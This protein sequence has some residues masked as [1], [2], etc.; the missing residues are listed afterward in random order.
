MKTVLCILT[1]M[2]CTLFVSASDDF[3]QIIE[4]V[5]IAEGKGDIHYCIK[6]AD[7][8]YNSNPTKAFSK[9]ELFILAAGA[10]GYCLLKDTIHAERLGRYP[11][12]A[13][14]Q[15]YESNLESRF[16]ILPDIEKK[17][18]IKQFS[19]ALHRI[20]NILIYIEPQK[21]VRLFEYHHKLIAENKQ[22]FAFNTNEED[23]IDY[24]I[25]GM[26][27]KNWVHAHHQVNSIFETYYPVIQKYINSNNV[28]VVGIKLILPFLETYLPYVLDCSSSNNKYTQYANQI[29]NYVLTYNELEL[30]AKGASSLKNQNIY[31]DLEIPIQSKDELI[32]T[33]H[34]ELQDF[35]KRCTDWHIIRDN[36]QKNEMA[37][38]LASYTDPYNHVSKDFAIAFRS[39]SSFPQ[40]ILSYTSQA[41]RES[42]NKHF[43]YDGYANAKTYVCYIDGNVERLD[44]NLGESNVY[45][46]FSLF[47][48]VRDKHESIKNKYGNGA[49]YLCADINYGTGMG[50]IEPLEESKRLINMVRE[51]FPSNAYVLSGNSVRKINFFNL[52]DDVQILHI[53]THGM[54]D[55][56]YLINENSNYTQYAFENVGNETYLCLSNYNANPLRNRMTATEIQEKIMLHNNCLVFLDACNTNNLRKTYYGS[57]S[58]AKAF[59]IAGARHVIAYLDPVNEKVATDFAISFYRKIAD[60]P[61]MTYHQAFYQTKKEIIHIYKDSGLINNQYG[62]PSLDVVLWE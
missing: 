24:L 8:V 41:G 26:Q 12:T 15:E 5:R 43:Q 45:R 32:K 30:W 4:R 19:S 48:I 61:N 57:N 23:L 27:D 31:I 7:G 29:A 6:V 3:S 22:L 21:A 60:N 56:D 34:N 51:L 16:N 53:S 59:Y 11:V 9:D 40:Q 58:L 17:R 14:L 38:V 49:V 50:N 33:I 54:L 42:T 20:N 25:C 39:S 35:D 2:C 18:F 1:T 13:F 52:V 36:L 44:S 62:E 28:S 47:D 37:V 55:Q 10:H 46:K